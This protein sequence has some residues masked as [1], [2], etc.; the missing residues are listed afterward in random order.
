MG[1]YHRIKIHVTIVYE[2]LNLA[3]DRLTNLTE[4][5]VSQSRVRGTRY[6]KGTICYK[7]LKIM[8]R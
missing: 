4:P 1:W 2:T 8:V 6:G 5:F 7:T 3:A